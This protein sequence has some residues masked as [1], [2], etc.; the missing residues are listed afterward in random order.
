MDEQTSRVAPRRSRVTRILWM[1]GGGLIGVLAVAA[2]T[3]YGL[4]Q[5][6][7]TKTYE[8]PQHPLALPEATPEVLAR[9]RHLAVTRGCLECHGENGE[10]RV[11]IDEMPVFTL[12]P[13]NLTPLG[14]TKSYSPEDWERAIRHGIR[15]DGSPILFMPCDD[16]ASM[17]DTDLGTLVVYLRSLRGIEHDPGKSTIGPVGRMLFVTG[18][19]PLVPAE[20]IDHDRPVPPAPAYAVTPEYGRYVAQTCVGCH[21]AGLSG[22]PIPGVPPEWPAA[23]NITSDATT[24]MGRYTL[25][26]FRS[27]MRTGKRVDGKQIDPQFMPWKLFAVMDE[28]EIDALYAYLRTVPAKAAGGR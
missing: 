4:S 10:G 17:D 7:F 16:F 14:L 21:G 15:P 2:V 5:R 13:G 12:A 27:V 20:H 11:F 28:V 3:V 26:G 19:L 8:L 23:G 25:D 1:V 9:G 18:A 22:G 6:R 24:G